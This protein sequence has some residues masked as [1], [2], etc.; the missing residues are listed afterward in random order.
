MSFCRCPAGPTKSSSAGAPTPMHGAAARRLPASETAPRTHR[1]TVG[2]DGPPMGGKCRRCR[3][4]ALASDHIDPRRRYEGEQV[5]R[6]RNIALGVRKGQLG[7][8]IEL[9]GEEHGAQLTLVESDPHQLKIRIGML[10]S[11]LEPLQTPARRPGRDIEL[12]ADRT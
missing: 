11:K 3:S 2:A 9:V 8:L 10:G 4:L 12:S 6:Q 1:G 5:R 7:D